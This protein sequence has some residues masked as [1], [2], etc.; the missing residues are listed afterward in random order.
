MCPSP[1]EIHLIDFE[2]AREQ[3]ELTEAQWAKACHK[4]LFLILQE[5]A[6]LQCRL[7]EQTG[8][9]AGAVQTHFDTL[10]ASPNRFRRAIQRQAGL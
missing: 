2:N 6:Y 5:A 9:L 10:F 4:D 1:L 3:T 8:P 7:G